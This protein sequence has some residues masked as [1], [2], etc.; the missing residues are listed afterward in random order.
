VQ[1]FTPPTGIES[2]SGARV[3]TAA[4]I[5]ALGIGASAM[6]SSNG[7]VVIKGS[8]F[9]NGLGAAA[10]S[11]IDTEKPITPLPVFHSDVTAGGTTLVT[12]KVNLDSYGGENLGAVAVLKMTRGGSVVRL[13]RAVDQQNL[14]SGAFI[15]TDALGYAISSSEEIAA[16]RSY[17]MSVAIEDNS[18]YD[19][20]GNLGTV[21]DPLSLAVTK[22]TSGGGYNGDG[23][24]AQS[25][26]GGCDAGGFGLAS[27]AILALGSLILAPRKKG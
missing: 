22:K 23:I 6:E 13:L 11:G 12:L 4:E 17:F 2:A 15:W 21:V 8:E 10:A 24:N 25:G 16:G 3:V 9:I 20:D 7:V 18:E 5:E 19:L 26:G 27:L 1:T 14:I